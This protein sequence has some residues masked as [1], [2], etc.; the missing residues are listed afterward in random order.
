MLKF[1]FYL[2]PVDE[3]TGPHVYVRGSHNRRVFKHQL[4]LLVG[5]PAQE[6]LGV[7]G[8]QSPITLTGEAGWSRFR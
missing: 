5:H 6:V 4:S 7:Y 1:F 8:Q 3:G 2:V